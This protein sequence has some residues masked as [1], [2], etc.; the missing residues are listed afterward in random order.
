MAVKRVA[1]VVPQAKPPQVN[2]KK[3]SDP[4]MGPLLKVFLRKLVH[5]IHVFIVFIG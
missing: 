2:R 3:E 1:S 4:L 5:F